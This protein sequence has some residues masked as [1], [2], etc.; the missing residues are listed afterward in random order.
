MIG[1]QYNA[2]K[3]I[4]QPMIFKKSN[5]KKFMSDILLEIHPKYSVGSNTVDYYANV[6]NRFILDKSAFEHWKILNDHESY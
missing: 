6:F 3:Q 1:V 2:A 4:S 5:L